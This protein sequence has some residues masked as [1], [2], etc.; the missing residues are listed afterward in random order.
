MRLGRADVNLGSYPHRVLA[1]REPTPPAVHVGHPE[2]GEFAPP[3]PGVGG[4]VD[5]S[6]IVARGLCQP[7]NLFV[8]EVAV[9]PSACS[10]AR[11]R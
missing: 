4:D 5:E 8:A 10:P 7:L 1:H 3:Q 2:R 6:R 11:T 9:K